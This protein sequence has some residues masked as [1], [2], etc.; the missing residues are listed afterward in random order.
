[1][2]RWPST[3]R[4]YLYGIMQIY[5]FRLGQSAHPKQKFTLEQ[6]Q[7]QFVQ[8]LHSKSPVVA[9]SFIHSSACQSKSWR[10]TEFSRVPQPLR[11]MSKTIPYCEIT[12]TDSEQAILK[13]KFWAFDVLMKQWQQSFPILIHSRDI[14]SWPCIML[15]APHC[16][17]VPTIPMS[18]PEDL[19]KC[20]ESVVELY[21][22]VNLQ[23]FI[24]GRFGSKSVRWVALLLLNEY[25][26]Y[27]ILKGICPWRCI[28][29]T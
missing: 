27:W 22:D 20:S 9:Q 16:D 21:G 2:Y 29:E 5:G 23:A 14:D 28:D 1:M 17:T 12:V 11:R 10:I 19:R 8:Q 25:S 24:L 6:L 15:D 4:P 13:G 3:P 7:D 18:T 26:E